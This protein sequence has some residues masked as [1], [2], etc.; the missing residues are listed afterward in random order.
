MLNVA[1]NE[2]TG[3]LGESAGAI[4][5]EATKNTTLVR[6][7]VEAAIRVVTDAEIKSTAPKREAQTTMREAQEELEALKNEMEHL[8]KVVIKGSAS[9]SHPSTAEYAAPLSTATNKNNTDTS[10]N[11]AWVRAPLML[12]LAC[13]AVW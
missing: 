5:I 2:F 11:P 10:S 8:D 13:V 12:L 1:V 9:G 4:A 3:A 7:S 6:H